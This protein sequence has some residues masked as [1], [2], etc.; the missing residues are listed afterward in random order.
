M[1]MLTRISVVPFWVVRLGLAAAILGLRS[2]SSALSTLNSDLASVPPPFG[3]FPLPVA[4]FLLAVRYSV[5]DIRLLS[6]NKFY[7]GIIYAVLKAFSSHVHF[8]NIHTKQ[9]KKAIEPSVKLTK[10]TPI[11]Q[12]P[13]QLNG[14]L[15][16]FK[17]GRVRDNKENISGPHPHKLR[18]G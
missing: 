10:I 9:S 18:V 14:Q 5:D 7:T 2:V 8:G 12:Y 1:V 16:M 4:H 17:F 15:Q 13:A 6:N 11:E 3:C